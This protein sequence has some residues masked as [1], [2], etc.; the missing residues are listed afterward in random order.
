MKMRRSLLAFSSLALVATALLMIACA[1]P[2]QPTAAP[3]TSAPAAPTSAPA[4]T[5][6]SAATSAPAPTAASA[7]TQPAAMKKVTFQAGYLAQ[8]NISFVAAY[9]AKEKGFFADEGLDVTIE[10]SSPGGGEQFQR[11]VAKD[12]QFTTQTGSDYVWQ[13]AN[14]KPPFIAVEVFG[15]NNDEA[16]LVLDDS[17]IKTIADMKG[18]KVGFKPAESTQP[19][20]ILAMLKAAGL[21]FKD[22]N[23]V[24]I[25]FDPRVILPEFG[26]GQVDVMQVFRSNEPDTLARMGYKT[27]LFKPA[28]VGV[29]FLG[30]LYIT[31]KDYVQSDPEM[32]RAFVRATTK[33]LAWALD[34]ANKNEVT[35]IVMK[36]AG[37]KA[38]RG[39]QE[40]IWT[41]EAQYVT[42]PSTQEVGLGYASDDEWN[43][44]MQYMV[45]FGSIKAPVPVSD[46]WDPQFVKSVYG[47]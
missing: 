20:W 6:A 43:K 35:D 5:S 44:M 32:I 25:G 39:H 4:A 37:E 45:D 24:Q 27:R 18:K 38:D 36:Y 10:H 31:N 28:D 33:A 1:A 26:A 14:T 23:L 16:L 15:H 30:Q 13:A 46:I 12:I 11:L 42:A 7:T 19:P 29:N 8:G 47:K 3:P 41:T 17:P 9:V 2:A 22:V 34:P 21:D 40:F